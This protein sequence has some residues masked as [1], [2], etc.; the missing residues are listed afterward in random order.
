MNYDAFKSNWTELHDGVHRYFSKLTDEDVSAIN[1]DYEK[2]VQVLQKRYGYSK[3][4]AQDEFDGYFAETS[5]NMTG[6][7]NI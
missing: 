7:S 2:L 5:R 6:T 4:R 3:E 1:G